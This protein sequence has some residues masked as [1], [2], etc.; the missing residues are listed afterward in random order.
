MIEYHDECCDCA[1]PGYP[2]L[3]TRCPL[4]KVAYYRCDICGDESVE[5]LDHY[6][7]MDLCIHCLE[8]ERGDDY[9]NESC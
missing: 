4:R 6:F 7:G 2:C 5:P 1:A 3:G 8:K 9:E